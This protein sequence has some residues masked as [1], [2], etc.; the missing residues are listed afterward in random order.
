MKKP[1]LKNKQQG[2]TLIEILVAMALGAF[3]LAGAMQI[4]LSSKQSYRM[5]DNMSRLQENGRFAM[6]FISRDIRMADYWG[7]VGSTDIENK[8]NIVLPPLGISGNDNDNDDNAVSGN[9][10][11]DNNNIWDRTDSI[12]LIGVTPGSGVKLTAEAADRDAAFIVPAGNSF[13][14][15]KIAVISNCISGDMF[16]ITND[17]SAGTTIEHAVA[18]LPGNTS[19]T[20]GYGAADATMYGREAQIYK[21][22]D[23]A[24]KINESTGGV[25]ALFRSIN[26]AASEPLVED[27][28]NMQITYGEDTDAD[29]TPNYFVDSDTVA[30]MGKVV[31]VR[32]TLTVRTIDNNL[33]SAG[34]GRLRRTFSSTL[35]LRNRLQ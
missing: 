6:E 7:C 26:G 3:L 17:V 13:E 12:A 20:L 33:T 34:D 8:V 2:M 32:I 14:Q 19:A 1:Y 9:N 23:V 18:G 4:F 22:N 11:Q 30:D 15:H 28:E 10:D 27:I 5:Q 25:P 24:Y 16:Q 29:G 35:V 31:S 21:V